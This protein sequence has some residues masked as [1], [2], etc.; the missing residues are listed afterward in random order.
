MIA[1]FTGEYE[2][3]SNFAA[4]PVTIDGKD[5][6]TIEHFFQACKTL[7]EGEHE[8]VRLATTPGRAK[9]MGRQVTLRPDWEA[10]KDKVMRTGLLHK[11]APGSDLASK[12]IATGAEELIEGNNWGDVR[13]GKV[14]KGGELVGENRLGRLLMEIRKGLQE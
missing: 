13:W 1:R 4:S 5:Y 9:K 2:F 7:D 8:G 6:A 12:L 10:V 14:W 3:L 11:F